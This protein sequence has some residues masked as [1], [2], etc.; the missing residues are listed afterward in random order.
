MMLMTLRL[1]IF[2]TKMMA[3]LVVLTNSK[4]N[5]RSFTLK[6][7]TLAAHLLKNIDSNNL[8]LFN[9]NTRRPTQRVT[10][11]KVTNLSNLITL[12]TGT[13]STAIQLKLPHKIK[14]LSELLN[15]WHRQH[16]PSPTLTSSATFA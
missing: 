6:L 14:Q 13:L 7:L 5:S 15:L 1:K 3:H 11:D 8:Y 2:L 16:Q 12:E 4:S 9:N 10:T